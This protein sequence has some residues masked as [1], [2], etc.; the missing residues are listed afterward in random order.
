MSEEQRTAINERLRHSPLDIG[1]DP[2]QMQQAFGGMMAATPLP[3]DV[4]TTPGELGG[5]P[6]LDITVGTGEPGAI[7]FWLHGGFYVF[8]SPAAS[9]SL[10]SSIA[11]RSGTHAVSV[12]STRT[13]ARSTDPA[14]RPLRRCNAHKRDLRSPPTFL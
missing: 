2:E 1:G 3:P 6:T 5:V 4:N 9:A 8:G 11:R 13:K 14:P 12:G 7:L 10:S